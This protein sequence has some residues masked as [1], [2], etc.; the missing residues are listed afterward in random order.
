[1]AG[2]YAA[3]MASAPKLVQYALCESVAPGAGGIEG[4]P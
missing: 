2:L 4:L 3:D 1:M